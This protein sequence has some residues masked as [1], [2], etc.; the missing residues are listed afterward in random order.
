MI[1]RRGTDRGHGNYGWLDTRY[2]FSFANYYNPDW[3][4]WNSLLVLNEDRIKAGTGFPMHS[5]EHMEIITYVISG[6]L[7]HKDSEGNV[8]RIHAGEFQYMT[9]GDGVT[10][11]EHAV[12]DTHLIQM[13]VK[14]N[15]VHNVSYWQGTGIVK[16]PK[17]DMI[18]ETVVVEGEYTINNSWAHI[19]SGKITSHDLVAGD[20]F[21]GT[22]IIKCAQRCKLLLL[23]QV[24]PS[25]RQD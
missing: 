23:R 12:E 7:E 8:G 14:P 10:H 17:L 18:I 11:S 19:I 24:S 9:A 2:T 1:I 16:D 13:W 4:G 22:T 5:H 21:G 20:S 15:G 25:F 3:M 6:V